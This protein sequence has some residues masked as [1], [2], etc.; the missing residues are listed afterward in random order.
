MN[1]LNKPYIDRLLRC[2]DVSFFLFGPRGSGKSTWLRHVLPSALYLDL[3][4]ASLFLEL[5]GDP[6]RL[7]AMAASLPDKAWIILDEI[8]KIP[9][10]LDEVHRLI[11]KRNWRFVLCGSSARKLRRGGANLLA[12]RAITVNMESFSA[13]EL[14]KALDL[15]SSLEWGLLPV[16]QR[17]PEQAPDILAA[18]L[19]TH[20]REEIRQ[21][22]LLRNVPPFMRF[23]SIAGQ[24]NGQVVNMQQ[25]DKKYP[26]TDHS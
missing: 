14:G 2:P 10:L 17:E 24:L 7:E 1:T 25:T 21:E 20:M 4:D 18:Y 13:V 15:D 6:H 5:S 12:G 19:D 9:A 26:W 8:Q 23:M 16:V 3:L 11:E 22:G